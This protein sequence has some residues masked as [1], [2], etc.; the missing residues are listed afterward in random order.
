MKKLL[1]I[2]AMLIT[3][4]AAQD[5]EHAPTVD[6]CH[7]DVAVWY[8]QS[9]TE[10]ESIPA[11]ELDARRHEAYMCADV[12]T[13]RLE[14]EKSFGEANV[15]ASHLQERMK[16]FLKRHGF[17]QQFADEDAKGAR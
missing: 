2:F 1:A 6:Q 3:G 9:K 17:M 16:D 13:D 14:R 11:H 10:I 5:I 4:A 8:K 12:L 15:Y 7:A